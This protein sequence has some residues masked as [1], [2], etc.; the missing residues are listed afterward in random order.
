[1]P[2]NLITALNL[3]PEK[4]VAYF[5]RKGLKIT[6]A[7]QEQAELNMAQAF[8][9]AKAMNISVLQD[10]RDELLRGLKEGTDFKEFKKELTPRLQ[11]KGWWPEEVRR[12]GKLVQLGAPRRL[13]VI[14]ENNI[15]NSYN[16]GRWRSFEENIEAQPFLQYVA[17]IDGSTTPICQELN[18]QIH[19]VDSNFW[20]IHAPGNHYGCRSRLRSITAEQAK[21]SKF[22]PKKM[23][24]K[25]GKGF[26]RNNAKEPWTPD[27]KDFDNDI[28]K[29][30]F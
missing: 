4:A 27:K 15:Q 8:T 26:E 12:D 20:G 3:P 14:Y 6:W 9:V 10:I 1:M 11:A 5:E 30:A 16:V 17:I 21:R 2:V 22:K 19:P 29:L 25:P 18:G 7:W 24:E 23:K 13:K 28:Y